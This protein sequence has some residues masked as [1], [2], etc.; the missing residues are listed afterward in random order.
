MNTAHFLSCVFISFACPPLPFPLLSRSLCH[1]LTCKKVSCSCFSVWCVST[2]IWPYVRFVAIWW[3]VYVYI[4]V[5]NGSCLCFDGC[6]DIECN[7]LT[8]WLTTVVYGCR[9]ANDN[10]HRVTYQKIEDCHD[11]ANFTNKKPI[12][13]PD[14]MFRCCWCKKTPVLAEKGK[15]SH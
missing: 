11:D 13:H 2:Y 5:Y 6:I 14:R 3:Y 4:Y 8:D 7:R 1:H 9:F 10:R 15:H 12:A